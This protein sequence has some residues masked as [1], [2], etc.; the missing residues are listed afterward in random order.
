MN[1][2]P[3]YTPDQ[4]ALTKAIDRLPGIRAKSGFQWPQGLIYQYIKVTDYTARGLLTLSRILCRR[5][6]EFEGKGWVLRIDHSDEEGLD[7]INFLLQGPI[8]GHPVAADLAKCIN[9]HVDDEVPG[10]NI[11]IDRRGWN[12]K[13]PTP[14][15]EDDGEPVSVDGM[16][17][18]DACIPRR[19]KS[20]QGDQ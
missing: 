6:Y 3:I 10:Y 8:D 16:V 1:S 18:A 2:K 19:P 7:A 11:L 4:Q 9:E 15:I 12:P 5:Y 20:K 14:F 17:R 13:F